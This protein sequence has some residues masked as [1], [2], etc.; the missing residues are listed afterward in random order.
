MA[1]LRIR[2]EKGVVHEIVALRGEKGEGAGR[3]LD[4]N[5]VVFN[6]YEKNQVLAKYSAGF[7]TNNM[8]GYKGFPISSITVAEDQLSAEVAIL[9]KDLV[10]QACSC[11]SENDIVQMDIG[12]HFYDQFKIT[13]KRV[14]ED[15]NSILT[16][17][18]ITGATMTQK[19]L[20]LDSNSS[21]NWIFVIGKPYGLSISH[22]TAVAVLGDGNIS[23]GNGSTALGK[24]NQ[25]IGAY[26]GAI[27]RLNKT[28]YAAFT[29][30]RQN[31][32][33]GH[34]SFACGYSNSASGHYSSAFGESST[35]SGIRAFA[36]GS[37]CNATKDNTFAGG[38][39]CNANHKNAF[40]FGNSITSKADY[41]VAF[42][43]F[44]KVADDVVFAVGN[45]TNTKQENAI[46]AFNDGHVEVQTQGETDNSVVTKQYV[47]NLISQ[48]EQLK[49]AI[50]ALGGTV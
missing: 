5:C 50:I 27:G 10:N 14:A 26:S 45:G 3:E 24:D 48:I 21:Q 1:I 16:I 20:V 40:I 7:G 49:Q 6:D 30:G 8:A 44:P 28:G 32:A 47:D 12:G 41:Q 38:N 35:A 15:G 25:S 31:S 42:G 43:S 23:A 13:A 22:Q 46:V 18:R 9:D 37:H 11:Y 34:Y 17:V 39:H 33:M 4:N 2:D 29:C 19:E 36:T